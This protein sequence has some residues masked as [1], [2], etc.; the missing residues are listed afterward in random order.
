[1]RHSIL[2]L[3]QFEVP[4]GPESIQTKSIKFCI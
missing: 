1:M 2:F 3:D 4:N